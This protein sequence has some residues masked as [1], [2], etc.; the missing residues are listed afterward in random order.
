MTVLDEIIVGVKEDLEK[1]KL[2]MSLG[3]V[4]ARAKSCAPALDVTTTFASGAFGLIAEVKRSSPSKG[5]LAEITDPASLAREYQRGGAAAIS[6]LTEERRFKGSLADLKA[7]RAA[8]TI[9]VLRKEFIVDP[10][11]IYEARAYGADIILLIVAALSE[12]E[13]IE[14]SAITHELGMRTLIEVHDHDEL[15]RVLELL[16]ARKLT[17]DLLGINARNLKTLAIDATIFAALAPLVPAA[18]PLIAESGISTHLQV[19]ELAE[20]GADGVLVGEALVKD[21]QPS[22]TIGAFLRRAE[23][24]R[25]RRLTP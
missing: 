11:Q 9:P 12:A 23:S 25:V 7:V 8:V 18:V 15:A 1:R 14:F 5:A 10:Y 22:T 20:Q 4:I 3:E 6:V 19:G 17:I 2:E 24:M 16:A 21:G 13:L